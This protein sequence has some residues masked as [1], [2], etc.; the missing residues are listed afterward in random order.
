MPSDLATERAG[1]DF[2]NLT[3]EVRDAGL[4]DR[5]HGHYLIRMTVLL[6]LLGGGWT[7]FAFLGSSWVQMGLAAFLGMIFTQIGFL[8]H[9]VGHGQ[10]TRSP[11]LN[12]VIGLVLGNL[13]IGLSFGWWVDKH[14]RHHAHPND[15]G[16]DPDVADGVLSF[17]DEVSTRKLTSG[18]FEQAVVRHQ[19]LL[20]FPLLLLEGLNLHVSG[21]REL[22]KHSPRRRLVEGTL[23]IAHFVLFATALLWVLSPLQA[24]VFLAVQQAMFGLYM[25]CAF[26]PNHKGM[27]MMGRGERLDFLTRQVLTSR[28]IRGGRVTDLMF[29]GLNYQVEH[30]L[31]P[32][33]PMPNLRRAQPFVRA[34]CDRI[35]LTYTEASIIESYRRALSSLHEL[36]APLRAAARAS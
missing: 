6:L 2:A 10:F 35:D 31:F 34:L 1:V 11:R 29:G 26:A 36:G 12:H 5:R 25:G 17:S 23:L 13:L 9:E 14:N 27:T 33:M 30:H 4:L 22:K 32:S 8:G 18:R 3:R 19:A 16:R 20:F 7:L 21:L 28:N 15:I 24:L